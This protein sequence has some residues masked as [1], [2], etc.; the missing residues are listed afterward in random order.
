MSNS[1]DPYPPIEEKLELTRRCFKFFSEQNIRYLVVTKSDMVV[2]DIE[3]IKNSR[4]AVTVTITTLD[5]VLSQKMEPNAPPPEKRIEAVKKL[6]KEKIPVGVRVDPIIYGLNDNE[7]ET[8]IE[9][10][11]PYVSHITFST[12]KPRYDSFKRFKKLFPYV[13]KKTENLYHLKI[14]NSFYLD[15]ELR[16]ELI[17]R[18]YEKAKEKG[19]S[20]GLCREGFDEFRNSPSCDGSHL[21]P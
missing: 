15:A 4:C 17:F 19:L 7:I 16:K 9:V 13:F 8:I 10:V 18:A 1:S 5:K 14:N 11:S 2:R 21:V 6:G 3:I 12:F 20:F